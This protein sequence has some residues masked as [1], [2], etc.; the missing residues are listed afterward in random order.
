M[1]RDAMLPC[2]IDTLH[3]YGDS[4]KVADGLLDAILQ[5]LKVTHMGRERK[6]AVVAATVPW[7]RVTRQATTKTELSS[8]RKLACLQDGAKTNPCLGA[9]GGFKLEQLF[10]KGVRDERY[11]LSL[12]HPML[13]GKAVD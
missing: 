13:E 3:W 12:L 11:R 8:Q 7:L 4:S 2:C 5:S 10:T 6:K 9:L 1:V